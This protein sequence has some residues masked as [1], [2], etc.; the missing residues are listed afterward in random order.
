MYRDG[1]TCLTNIFK[2]NL[3]LNLNQRAD[4]SKRD[5]LCVRENIRNEMNLTNFR[6]ATESILCLPFGWRHRTFIQSLTWDR[7]CDSAHYVTVQDNKVC[8]VRTV[9]CYLRPL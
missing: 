8:T 7:K 1:G 9:A 6:A 4:Y 2:D 5:A 3:N